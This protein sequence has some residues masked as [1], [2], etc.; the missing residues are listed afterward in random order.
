MGT[1]EALIERAGDQ[2]R[3]FATTLLAEIN[4]HVRL[5]PLPARRLVADRFLS[6][7]GWLN[8]KRHDLT[9]T[10]IAGYAD[11]WLAALDLKGQGTLQAVAT[12]G[13]EVLIVKRKGCCLDYLIDPDRLCASCPRQDDALRIARQTANALAEL[14]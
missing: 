9:N 7:M 10:Q 3:A 1:P 6:L 2:F 5:K 4:A 8:H 12:P 14:G 13:G 11:Q